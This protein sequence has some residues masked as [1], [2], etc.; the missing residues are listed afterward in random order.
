MIYDKY[1]FTVGGNVATLNNQTTATQSHGI[2]RN[3]PFLIMKYDANANNQAA[4]DG[5]CCEI[6]NDTNTNRDYVYYSTAFS[7]TPDINTLSAADSMLLDKSAYTKVAN[8]LLSI[9]Q[10]NLTFPVEPFGHLDSSTLVGYTIPKSA[11]SAT[12]LFVYVYAKDAAESEGY[13]GD[14]GPRLWWTVVQS[15]NNSAAVCY[16]KPN[17]ASVSVNKNKYERVSYYGFA[18]TNLT[19][20]DMANTDYVT[21]DLH[22]RTPSVPSSVTYLNDFTQE[23]E[24]K[25]FDISNSTT[26]NISLV[27]GAIL[28]QDMSVSRDGLLH[29]YYNTYIDLLDN[30]SASITTELPYIRYY[31]PEDS[32][33]SK[34]VPLYN[35]ATSSCYVKQ[36]NNSHITARN[37]QFSSV[38]N[39][40]ILMAPDVIVRPKMLLTLPKTVKNST[41]NYS[42]N[43]T[44]Y[45]FDTCNFENST[46]NFSAYNS[47]E[48]SLTN[49]TANNS[50][51]NGTYYSNYTG[52]IT[53]QTL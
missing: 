45:S 17:T 43:Y 34:I 48:L 38:N 21:D 36:C 20:I 25:Y 12:D 31:N 32:R 51:I 22:I 13:T 6:H 10:N 44:N 35:T 9:T 18:Y 15:G 24:T 8:T 33:H 30:S 39:S 26:Q 5:I 1:M 52:D 50:Y 46:V 42:A 16:Y 4:F 14:Y 19:A 7:L 53:V 49:I 29:F 37:V 40:N 23:Y 2:P 11:Y 47:T 28:T 41:I 3:K 27:N